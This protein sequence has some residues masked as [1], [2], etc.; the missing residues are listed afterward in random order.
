MVNTQHHLCGNL[1]EMFSL[2]LVVRKQANSDLGTFYNWPQ[3]AWTLQKYQC[4]GKK[5]ERE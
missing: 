4:H 5:L 2:N 3:M 1:I